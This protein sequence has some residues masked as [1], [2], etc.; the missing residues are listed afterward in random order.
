MRG[1]SRPGQPPASSAREHR[2]SRGCDSRT[3]AAAMLP[4]LHCRFRSGTVQV[5]F[6]EYVVFAT[7]A[8]R[9]RDLRSP[10]IAR[11]PPSAARGLRVVARAGKA[12]AVRIFDLR[13]GDA[14]CA[15]TSRT[16]A[17][18]LLRQCR[19]AATKLGLQRRRQRRGWIDAQAEEQADKDRRGVEKVRRAYRRRGPG[20]N[21]C[22]HL[23]CADEDRQRRGT[24]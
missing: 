19:P 13:S 6:A 8:R 11:P 9:P 15:Q 23:E 12:T 22:S 20:M 21:H 4:A 1:P 14:P 3:R 18:R 10:P 2:T 7:A 16:P 24:P 5:A 17:W